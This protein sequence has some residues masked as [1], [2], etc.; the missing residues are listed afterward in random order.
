VLKQVQ[1]IVETTSSSSESENY[2]EQ[3]EKVDDVALFMRM[4]HKG[5]KKQ[6][7]KVVKRK[8]R[9]RGHATIVGALTTSLL[10]AHMRSRTTN[11]RK[12]GRRTR[13]T[14]RRARKI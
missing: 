4:Y 5:L 8:T 13:S 14:T 3:Y 11:T 12:R 1:E 6:G 9:R 7:Y 10:S 2:D